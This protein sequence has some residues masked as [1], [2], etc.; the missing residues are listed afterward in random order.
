MARGPDLREKPLTTRKDFGSRGI[1]RGIRGEMGV[2]LLG[3]SLFPL[4]VISSDFFEI[5]TDVVATWGY[6]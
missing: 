1:C 6:M 3:V 2:A 5:A 4:P